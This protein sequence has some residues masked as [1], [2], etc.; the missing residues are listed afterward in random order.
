MRSAKRVSYTR[1]ALEMPKAL[2]GEMAAKG[3]RAAPEEYLEGLAKTERKQEPALAR[4]T[5]P[6]ISTVIS[7][8][9]RFQSKIAQIATS[10]CHK[11]AEGIVWKTYHQ[12]EMRIC[13][14]STPRSQG[15]IPQINFEA[16]VSHR[17]RIIQWR[18]AESS[19]VQVQLQKAR[20]FRIFYRRASIWKSKNLWSTFW[21]R[22]IKL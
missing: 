9:C 19:L 17:N 15:K 5:S 20:N 10:R 2:T 16:M 6:V 7:S 12:I 3:A 14:Q 21:S 18:L 8:H 22:S 11:L 1:L 4:C 13:H